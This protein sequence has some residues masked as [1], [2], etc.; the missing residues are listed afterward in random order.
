MLV[1]LYSFAKER[2]STAVP[3]TGV[4]KREFDCIIKDPFTLTNPTLIFKLDG[5][6]SEMYCYI[7]DFGRFYFIESWTFSQNRWIATTSVDVLGSRRDGIL[8]TT[9]YVLRSASQF[10]RNI[11]DS[12]YPAKSEYN[13]IRRDA[14][15]DFWVSSPTDVTF[16]LDISGKGN[17]TYLYAFSYNQFLAFSDYLLGSTEWLDLSAIADEISEQLSKM[18]FNPLDYIA[19]CR[20]YPI[21]YSSFVS[22]MGGTAVTSIPFG[23]WSIKTNASR[24]SKGQFV[25][26]LQIAF[27]DHPQAADRGNWLNLAPYT[28]ITAYFPPFGIFEIPPEDL[29]FGT[30]DDLVGRFVKATTT[31][32][33]QSGNGVLR[34][35]NIAGNIILEISS[36]V[37]VDMPLFAQSLDRNS[38]PA[39]SA[40]LSGA[41]AIIANKDSGTDVPL[42]GA[43]FQN[44]LNSVNNVFGTDFQAPSIRLPDFSGAVKNF[45]SGFL[46]ASSRLQSIGSAGSMAAYSLDPSFMVVHTILVDDDNSKNGRPLAKSVALNTLSGYTTC[47]NP[48]VALTGYTPTENDAVNAYL[49]AGFYIE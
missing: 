37:G 26:T 10:D 35:T 4:Q 9:Q 18:M 38:N 42:G 31:I 16:V 44:A 23:W 40:I 19:S 20:I 45:V 30:V 13:F 3:D 1:T 21:K 36:K 29:V 11:A 28:R 7:P 6:P 39:M 8:A 43:G 15:A 41:N 5:I 48:H 47:Q 49:A 2:N 12:Y 27:S 32:D 24:I 25:K 33:L 22:T 46:T 14:A 34:F 17:A